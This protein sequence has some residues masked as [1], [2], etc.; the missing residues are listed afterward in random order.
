[1]ANSQIRNST[2]RIMVVDDEDDII[3]ELRVVLE[4]NG[5]KVDPFNDPLLA[6]ENFKAGLYDLLILDI[7]MPKMNGFE[8]YKQ[9]K[10][11]DNKVKTMF[12]TALTE[13]QEYEEF[14]KEVSPKLGERYFVPKPIENEDLI[15]RVNKILSQIENN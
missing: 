7:K 8:L 2:P 1:M 6:L 4:Q 5:F 15:K 3:L 9:I 13:L 14:R 10:K 12:L 11:V